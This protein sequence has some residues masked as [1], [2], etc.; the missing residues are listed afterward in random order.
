ME[1][2]GK[3]LMRL[4]YFFIFFNILMP[5]IRIQKEDKLT[6]LTGYRLRGTGEDHKLQ[7]K[8]LLCQWAR[9]M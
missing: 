9:L 2:G 5:L 7:A 6:E 1:R 8:R 4:I 3:D